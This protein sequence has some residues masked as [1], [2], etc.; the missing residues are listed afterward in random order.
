MDTS[1]IPKVAPIDDMPIDI[2][3]G[4]DVVA[5][6]SGSEKGSQPGSNDAHGFGVVITIDGRIARFG[7][8]ASD[9][10]ETT[11]HRGYL[12]AALTALEWFQRNTVNQPCSVRTNAEYIWL[13]ASERL[14][15]WIADDRLED[16][17]A[18]VVE[19]NDLW[20]K[21][22]DL[23]PLIERNALAWDA[24]ESDFDRDHFALALSAAR[25]ASTVARGNPPSKEM[26]DALTKL[27]NAALD[28][29]EDVQRKADIE[30]A[31]SR[32]RS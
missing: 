20:R 24:L 26:K 10:E 31:V 30:R 28:F 11:F 2:E 6:V 32:D 18:K 3:P 8:H 22:A 21:V 5:Y 9:S 15:G 19:N 16:S 1:R 27:F 25:Y 14:A 23:I 4:V 17:N 12:G 29:D 13:N 7:Y